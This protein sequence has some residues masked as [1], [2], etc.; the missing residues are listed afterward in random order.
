MRAALLL[1]IALFSSAWQVSAQQPAPAFQPPP[2]EFDWLQ[3]VTGE[4]LKGELIALYDGSL[5]FESDQLD[6]LSI[7]FADVRYLR[8]NRVVQARFTGQPPVTGKLVV[9]GDKVSIIGT[10]TREFARATLITLVGGEPGELNYWSGKVIFGANLRSG[11]TDQTEINTTARAL[12]RTVKSRVGLEYLGNYNITNDVTA[13]DNQ[14]VAGDVDWFVTDRLFIRPVDAEYFKDSFQNIAHRETFGAALGYQLV[15][16]ARVDWEVSAGPAYQRTS[17]VSVAEG[18][19]ESE[20]TA[21]LAISTTYTNELTGDIDYLL[22]YRFLFTRE[23]AGKFNHHFVTGLT[24]DSVGFLDIDL[25]FVWDHLNK[26][27]PDASGILPKQNDYRLM[28]GLGFD[29]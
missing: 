13:A 20:S 23:E 3:F 24:L 1:T 17:F 2:D 11:N 18:Q 12:R 9:D 22:D 7:D 4:W 16:S 10:D 14:R 5:E 26:P 6:V 21:A 29:F 27:R 28:F 19:T 25:T 8:T 15:D